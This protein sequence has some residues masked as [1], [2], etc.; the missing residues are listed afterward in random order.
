MEEYKE[1]EHRVV[2][3]GLGELSVLGFMPDRPWGDSLVK[4]LQVV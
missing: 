4:D 1:L 3:A 2:M